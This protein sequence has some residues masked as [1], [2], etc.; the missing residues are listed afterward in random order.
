RAGVEKNTA[1]LNP[2]S[3]SHE[4]TVLPTSPDVTQP[5]KQEVKDDHSG[6]QLKSLEAKPEE[7]TEATLAP[8]VI[9]PEDNMQTIHAGPRYGASIS[10]QNEHGEMHHGI[11]TVAL[12]KG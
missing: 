6:T 12:M 10:V 3:I 5:L 2:S 4:D 11:Q 1:A 7:K 9:A 8:S